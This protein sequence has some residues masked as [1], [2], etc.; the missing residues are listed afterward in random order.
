MELHNIIEDIVIPRTNEI[1]DSLEKEGNA[2]GICT[3]QQCRMDTSCYVLNRTNPY[4]VVSN[5]GVARIHMENIERQQL[6]ADITSLI[7]EGIKTVHHNQ[8]FN[9]EHTPA[10]KEDK[11]FKD[12]PAFSIPA[13]TGRLFDGGNFSPITGASIEILFNGAPAVMQE[14]HWQNPL[15]S[16][17]HAEGAFSFWPVPVPAKKI[18][19]KTAFQYVLRVEAE[20]YEP[21]NHVFRIPL[22]SELLTNLSFT[23]EKNFKLPDLFLFAH[24]EAEQDLYID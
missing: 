1:Y 13:I 24:G 9:Y 19:E 22:V 3:C 17:S 14:G 11:V 7:H 6:T 23:L 10:P 4:Y 8:R 16:E 20:G 2:E 15:H 21:L 18:G 5:R 12:K